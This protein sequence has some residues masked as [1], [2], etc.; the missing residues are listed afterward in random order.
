MQVFER[1]GGK[2][3]QAIE[4]SWIGAPK[5]EN[6]NLRAIN[7]GLKAGCEDQRFCGVAYK[8]VLISCSGRAPSELQAVGLME[9]I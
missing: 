4:L 7:S 1:Y 8:E 6:E 9:S 3:L 5:K 2:Y